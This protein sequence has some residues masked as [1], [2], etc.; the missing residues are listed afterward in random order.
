MDG[1]ES[2]WNYMVSR[3]IERPRDLLCYLKKCKHHHV[4]GPLSLA[5][6]TKAES[7]YSNWLSNEI[8]DALQGHLK[9]WSKAFDCL[10]ELNE[11]GRAHV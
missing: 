8:R 7:D 11:I 10:K 1:N 9:E 5:T 6:V 2:I 3:T 4:G